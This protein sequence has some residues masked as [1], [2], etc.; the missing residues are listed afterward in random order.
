[1]DLA[2][3]E[4]LAP[5][6]RAYLDGRDRDLLEPLRFLEPGR[7]PP[8]DEPAPAHARAAR[9]RLARALRRTNRSYGHPGADRLAGLLADPEVRVVVAGQQP[10]L[11]GGP[12]YT[13]SKM[14]AVA[15][16]AEALNGAQNETPNGAG[17][18]AVPV[19]WV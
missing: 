13:L 16:W 11:F 10:G 17:P 15:R 6:P 8:A 4:M 2:T 5:L 18:R 3:E 19:F 7:L 9:P 14:V 12:L 1:M